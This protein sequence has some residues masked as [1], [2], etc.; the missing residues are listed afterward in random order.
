MML[1]RCAKGMVAGP[2]GMAAGLVMVTG[3]AAGVAM[4]AGLVGAALIGRRLWEERSGWRANATETSDLP[5]E[6]PLDT[7]AS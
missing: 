4:G 2:V 1:L 7:P 3:V 6:G 5:A